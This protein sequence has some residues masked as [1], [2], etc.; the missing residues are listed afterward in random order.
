MKTMAIIQLIFVLELTIVLDVFGFGL[1]PSN[2]PLSQPTDPD[3]PAENL[4]E[5]DTAMPKLVS[6]PIDPDLP[7]ENLS[8]FDSVMVNLVRQDENAMSSED[9]SSKLNLK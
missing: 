7:E 4:S 3:V 5:F 2:S 6:Q 9:R 1:T 8:E